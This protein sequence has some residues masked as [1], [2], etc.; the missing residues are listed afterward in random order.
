MAGGEKF[1]GLLKRKSQGQRGM[2]EK[3]GESATR[4][5]RRHGC[6]SGYEGDRRMLEREENS[7][8]AKSQSMKSQV[9]VAAMAGRD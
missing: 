7:P 8:E 4:T 6:G 2:P 5:G 9:A 3:S 1:D